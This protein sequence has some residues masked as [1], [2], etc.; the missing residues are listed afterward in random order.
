MLDRQRLLHGTVD[1]SALDQ[2][3]FQRTIHKKYD[4]TLAKRVLCNFHD[5]LDIVHRPSPIVPLKEVCRNS[6]CVCVCKS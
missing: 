4:C 5:K 2:T 1:M 3:K 6:V